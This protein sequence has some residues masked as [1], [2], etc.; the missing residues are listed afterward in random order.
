MANFLPLERI[1][2]LNHP[3]A[4]EAQVE[5]KRTWREGMHP[6]K[7]K[8]VQWTAMDVL[9]A[10]ANAR[11]WMTAKAGRPDIHRAGNAS[12]FGEVADSRNCR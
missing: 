1:Y 10:F 6:L 5:D 2:K 12:E 11:G 3:S 9:A 4:L 7:A 8:P